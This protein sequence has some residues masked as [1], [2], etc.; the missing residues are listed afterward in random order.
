MTRR[1]FLSDPCFSAPRAVTVVY[2]H[3]MGGDPWLSYAKRF[4][5]SYQAN[6]P[7]YPHNTIIV[8][9]RGQPTAATRSLFAPVLN[10]SYL[11]H[12]NSGYDIGAFQHAARESK[13]DLMVFF[14]ASTYLNRENWLARMVE[15]WLVHGNAQY[16]AMG[17]RGDRG[18]QVWPH[19]RTTAFWMDPRLLAAYPVKV[20]SR[21]DR[22]Q[23]E[24]GPSCFTGWVDQQGLNSWVITWDHDLLWADWDSDPNG[25]LHGSQTGLL[26]GD[27]ISERK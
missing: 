23:F 8:C 3:V 26:A 12:D 27:H 5:A 2:V 20:I 6:G 16:G 17:N 19:I 15:A 24:H 10:V 13:S 7:G 4:V 1:R 14:G 18:V 25:F 21:T 11:V 9:N 22:Y